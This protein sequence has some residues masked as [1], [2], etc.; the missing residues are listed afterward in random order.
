[1]LSRK[2]QPDKKR[3]K[4]DTGDFMTDTKK[5][6]VGV[7]CLLFAFSVYITTASGADNNI[8]DPENISVGYNDSKGVGN[9]SENQQYYRI[10]EEVQHTYESSVN[11]ESTYGDNPIHPALKEDGDI[12]YN[13]IDFYV[14]SEYKQPYRIS[15]YVNSLEDPHIF[16]G[17]TSFKAYHNFLVPE[18]VKKIKKIVIEI[19]P[20]SY[21]YEDIKIMHKE[22]DEDKAVVDDD[23]TVSKK[24]SF[25]STL[26]S[27]I[28][29]VFACVVFAL[30]F[31]QF[32]R[33]RLEHEV[34]DVI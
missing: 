14:Y 29:G 22:I 31:W 18:G 27:F 17:M 13:D 28:A 34:Q 21:K 30:G 16:E 8:S 15:I 33:H 11:I 7:I 12:L 20:H 10:P 9:F 19:G 26:Q 23:E 6:M 3:R 32:W 25:M 5:I 4:V 24:D 1:V 2:A